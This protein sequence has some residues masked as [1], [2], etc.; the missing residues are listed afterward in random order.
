M[1]IKVLGPGCHNCQKLEEMVRN[2]LADTGTDALVQKVTAI[3]DIAASGILRTPGLI[4]NEKIM[5]QGK[6]PTLETL[7]H[8]IADSAKEN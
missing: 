2:A 5:S 7:K 4:I 1:V 8:W 3:S 6:I